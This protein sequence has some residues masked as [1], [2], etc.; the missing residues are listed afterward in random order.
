MHAVGCFCRTVN[1]NGS[2]LHK[3]ES[4]ISL[5]QKAYDLRHMAPCALEAQIKEVEECEQEERYNL[6][7]S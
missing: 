4:L 3:K 6:H 7:L 1:V 5:L 2:F